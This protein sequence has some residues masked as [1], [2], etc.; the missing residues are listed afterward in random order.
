MMNPGERAAVIDPLI[1][2]PPADVVPLRAA[3]SSMVA[4]Q[5]ATH[6]PS[7][8]GG[9]P[10]GASRA[11]SVK[12]RFIAEMYARA[13][14]SM[15]LLSAE[16]PAQLRLPVRAAAMLPLSR[17][18]AIRLSRAMLSGL[19]QLVP[20][21]LHRQL[22]LTSA[23]MG[24]LDVLLDESASKGETEVLRIASLVTRSAPTT[25]LQVEQTI[26]T[27]TRMIRRDESG[28]QSTYWESVLV[29]AVQEYCL[30]EALAVAY[31]PDARGVG[32]R[33]AGIDCAIK[34]MWYVVGPSMGLEADLSRFEKAGWNPQQQ[35]MA[36][37]SLLMQ[38]IDD[39]VDQDEDSGHRLTPVATG[40]WNTQS[41]DR[42]YRKT[43]RDLATVLAEN[44]IRSR[45][46]QKLFLDLY[47][48]Y[49][50]V[51]LDSMRTGMAA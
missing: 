21:S 25:Q 41:V 49:L 14:Y 12:A 18:L 15:L 23:L 44:G 11:Q 29:P 35:W 37:T 10:L 45:T 43:T 22:L 7:A 4:R 48:D 28:W 32:H 46:F 16:G 39:W 42:L 24:A 51:A 30:A 3:F 2:R 34:G 17:S 33:L 47:N 6:L 5:W 38:M 40:D 50:H 27:L 36:D 26:A 19:S 13:C 31:V 1:P 9:V 8:T 20:R